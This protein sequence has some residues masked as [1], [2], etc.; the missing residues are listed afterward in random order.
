MFG[1]CKAT[2]KRWH[3]ACL[4]VWCVC[5][6]VLCD[7]CACVCCVCLCVC[8]WCVCLCVCRVIM[9]SFGLCIQY[10]MST[11]VPP[12]PQKC[13]HK[14][15]LNTT[16]M[17]IV[18]AYLHWAHPFSLSLPS[19]EHFC[20]CVNDCLHWHVCAACVCVCG[21]GGHS[22]CWL[23]THSGTTSC[24]AWHASNISMW[25]VQAYSWIKGEGGGTI[26]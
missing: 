17:L 20:L 22:N 3:G 13:T 7:V 12:S 26:I 23:C 18:V 15:V 19:V 9:C 6:H 1:R 25:C 11:F 2:G 16:T 4:C 24:M 8:V 5:L 14:C 21:G 10:Q